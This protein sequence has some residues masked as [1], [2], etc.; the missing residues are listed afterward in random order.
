MIDTSGM[1]TLYG[2]FTDNESGQTAAQTKKS[3][4]TR[5]TFLDSCRLILQ[6]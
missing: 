5:W 4:G 6:G 1:S 3:V 2:E